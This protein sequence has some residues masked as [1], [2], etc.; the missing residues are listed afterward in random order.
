M[1]SGP[2][3]ES[4]PLRQALALAYDAGVIVDKLQ[5]RG[6]RVAFNWVP[7]TVLTGV[8]SESTVGQEEIFGPI[9]LIMSFDTVDEAIAIANGTQNPSR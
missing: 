4:K 1:T 2:L 6:Q 9:A 8:T 3:A 7:P 5:P